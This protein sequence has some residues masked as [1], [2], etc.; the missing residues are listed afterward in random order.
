VREDGYVIRAEVLE[1]DDADDT[2]TSLGEIDATSLAQAVA[3]A[4]SAEHLNDD[5]RRSL[6]TMFTPDPD[7]DADL[8]D[9]LVQYAVLGEIRFG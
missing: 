4:L 5:L 3:S 6:S 9:V 2:Y 7:V 8:A 1:R